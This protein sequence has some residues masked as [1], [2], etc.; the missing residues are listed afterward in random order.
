[1]IAITIAEY[2]GEVDGEAG[3]PYSPPATLDARVLRA[4]WWGYSRGTDK[5]KGQG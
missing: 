1:M 3:I 5:R 4:Y 2:R